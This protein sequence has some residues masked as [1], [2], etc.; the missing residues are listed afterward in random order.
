MLIDPAAVIVVPVPVFEARKVKLAS[1]LLVRESG[2]AI[3]AEVTEPS[4]SFAVSTA[5]S[6]I[7][8]GVTALSA[9]YV[10]VIVLGEDPRGAATVPSPVSVASCAT[11]CR[12]LA[13]P[14]STRSSRASWLVCEF[15]LLSKLTSAVCGLPLSIGC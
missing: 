14:S 12:S 5:L 2:T 10:L 15:S 13:E 11:A 7:L 6:E 8:A 9:R 4:A 3:F 1:A